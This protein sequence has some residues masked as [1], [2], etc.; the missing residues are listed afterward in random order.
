M[1]QI[2]AEIGSVHDGSF[3][4]ACKLIEVAAAC[5]ADT[6]KFQTHLPEA[7]TLRDAPTP[8]YFRGEPRFDYF[9]RTGFS[10]EQ[11][12]GLKAACEAAGVI[13]LSS[14]FSLEAVDLLE[15]VGVAQYKV[16]SGEVTNEPLLERIAETGKPTLLSSGMSNWAELDRAVAILRGS[17]PLVVMQCTSAY[18]CPHERVG[19]NVL[20]E[21]QNRYRLPVGYSDHTEG[22]AAAM[23]SAALGAVVIEKHLT[24]SRLMYG[25]DA[26]NAMEPNDFK[27]YSDGV[28]SIWRMSDNPVDKDDLGPVAEMK[29]IFEKS[30]VAAR[31]LPAGA[32]LARTDLAFKKAGHGISAAAYRNI[33]GR[34][35]RD[36]VAA[37]HPFSEQD[38]T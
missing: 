37:D 30:I 23:A 13:F 31:A 9:R 1:R 2:I 11:W 20:I 32:V 8:A 19:L 24:F 21:M 5:G 14:P 28:R 7:E 35:L 26:A 38:F 3:G 16:P 17:T 25:S 29:R 34:R 33:I 15:D 12:R 18:P 27:V 22:V 6:V 36:A 4:N 10:R